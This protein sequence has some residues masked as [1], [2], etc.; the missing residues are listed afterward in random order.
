MDP[1]FRELVRTRLSEA[2]EQESLA[3][4]RPWDRLLVAASVVA[5][6]GALGA[7]LVWSGRQDEPPTIGQPTTVVERMLDP[8]PIDSG[9]VT[10]VEN[11]R[12]IE[13]TVLRTP[14]YFD[15]PAR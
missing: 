13:S 3:P 14:L 12:R 5:L 8:V 2:Y 4:R 7:A 10:P 6:F 9:D 15:V 11:N 1:D